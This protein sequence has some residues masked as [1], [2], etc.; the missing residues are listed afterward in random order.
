M[1]NLKSS[2][3]DLNAGF[4]KASF[5]SEQRKLNPEITM[6]LSSIDIMCASEVEEFFYTNTLDPVPEGEPVGFDMESDGSVELV[7][8]SDVFWSA[9]EEVE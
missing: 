8:F 7:L 5:L 3:R 1:K 2:R 4:G 6:S 9:Q